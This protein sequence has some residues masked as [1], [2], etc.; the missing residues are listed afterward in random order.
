VGASVALVALVTLAALVTAPP[1]VTITPVP[2]GVIPKFEGK[3][4]FAL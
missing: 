2:S 1:A 4:T 3:G